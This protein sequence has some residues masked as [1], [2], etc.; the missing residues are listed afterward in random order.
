MA[1]ASNVADIL[2]RCRPRIHQYLREMYEEVFAHYDAL[3]LGEM[4]CGITPEIAPDFISREAAKEELDLILHFEHVELDCVNGDKWVLRDWA[5]PELKAAVSK[6]QTRMAEVGGWDTIWMENHDQ[7]RALSRY[8]KEAEANRED[9]AKLLAVWL[10]TLQGTV[11]IFQ[12]QELGMTNPKEFSEEM[13]RDIETRIYW[14][15][16]HGAL[17]NGEDPHKFEMVKKT[18]MTK[19]RD[20]SRIPIPVST[21]RLR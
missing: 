6:W 20:T 21:S 10:C 3:S 7:P 15:A 17:A 4:S 12:G 13:V 9:A 8:C 11:I 1:I 2:M 14:N 5:L 19:G 18:I 16:T